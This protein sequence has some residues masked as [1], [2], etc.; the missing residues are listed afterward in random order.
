MIDNSADS[1]ADWVRA[2]TACRRRRGWLMRRLTERR[3]DQWR[4]LTPVV[5]DVLLTLGTALISLVMLLVP[6]GRPHEPVSGPAILLILLGTLPL[7]ARRRLPL[8]ALAGAE[9]AEALYLLTATTYV[10]SCGLAVAVALYTLA[11]RTTRRLSLR[12]AGWIAGIN[13]A[14]IAWEG[15]GFG[16]LNS[17]TTLIALIA[18][19]VGSWSLGDNVRTRRAYLAQLEER[20][21]RLELEREENARRAVRDERTRIAREL[22]DVVAH[23]VSAIAVQAGA[24]EEIVER[25]PQRAREALHVIQE[26]SRQALIEMR[27]LLNVLRSGDEAGREREPQPGMAQIDRLIERS[28]AAGLT[29][30]LRVEG[31]VQPLPEALDLSAYRIVQEALT[32]SIKHAGPAHAC[33]LVRYAERIL[34]LDIRDDGRGQTDRSAGPPQGR[35]LIGMRERVALFGGDMVVGPTPGQGFRVGVRLPLRP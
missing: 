1:G 32:N 29:V 9:T 8:A 19:V 16:R 27:A 7:L 17:G 26:T 3:L 33:V 21:H 12:G 5:G 20:A 2:R 31:T 11:T 23:H 28:R 4:G 14:I 30:T 22:H 18:M 24:A 15:I 35:G 6:A 25:N 13:A 34:E 10:A